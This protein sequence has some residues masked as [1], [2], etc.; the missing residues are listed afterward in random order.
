[1]IPLLLTL[2]SFGVFHASDQAPLDSEWSRFTSYSRSQ[3]TWRGILVSLAA[4]GG[5]PEMCAQGER[6]FTL[7]VP[8]GF[9]VERI[10]G[11]RILV[12]IPQEYAVPEDQGKL[13][14]YLFTLTDVPDSLQL[15]SGFRHLTLPREK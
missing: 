8:Y 6:V 10:E 3:S 1:M 4:C 14:S 2:Y 11:A 13:R 12:E 5:D 7:D 9:E 15:W